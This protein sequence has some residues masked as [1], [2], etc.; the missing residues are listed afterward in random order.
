MGNNIRIEVATNINI[1]SRKQA[2]TWKLK[3]EAKKTAKCLT[4][5]KP[6]CGPETWRLAKN[7]KRSYRIGCTAKIGTNI[8]LDR[9]RNEVM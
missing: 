2:M 6:L 1:S 7:L 4:G 8:P 9:I 3:V 5:T